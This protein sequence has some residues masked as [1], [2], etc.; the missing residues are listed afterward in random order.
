MLQ[1]EFTLPYRTA[2][3]E[4]IYCHFETSMQTLGS[5]A[6]QSTDNEHWTARLN[7]PD[8]TQYVR[9]SYSVQSA[10][11][12]M[13][14]REEGVRREINLKDLQ[15][16][17]CADRWFD[18]PLEHA[19][20][21]PSFV[22]A[23]MPASTAT[24]DANKQLHM[25]LYAP[26]PPAGYSW[27]IVGESEALGA[28][29]PK[30]AL[31]LKHL[32][33]CRWEVQLERE[34][35]IGAYK[36]ILRSN[37][38]P[39]QVI[40]EAGENRS[41]SVPPY[42]DKGHIFH[43]DIAPEMGSERWRT[44]GVVIPMFSLRSEGSQG[45]G[46]FGDLQTMID[47]AVEVGMHAVQLLPINDTTAT[48]TASDSY[49]YNAISVFALHP[50][51][52]DLRPWKE[53]AYY[54]HYEA[55]FQDLNQKAELDYEGVYRAKLACLREIFLEQGLRILATPA[56]KKFAKENADWL[57]AYALFCTLRKK[58]KT[59]N[60]RLWQELAT[61]DTY[62]VAHYL[63]EHPAE[64]AEMDFYCF[65]QFLLFEQMGRVHQYARTKGVLLKGD[66]PI[67]VNRNSA[68]AW[69][70]PQLFHFNGQAGAPPDVFAV[71]GQNWGFPTYNWE[72]MKRNGYA[73]W[74]RRLEVMAQ[75]FDAY[76]IDHVLGFF[77]I[78][79][80]PFEQTQGV[81]G[82]FRPAL[83]YTT[84]E[85]SNF[86]FASSVEDYAVP[87]ITPARLAEL[88]EQ[89][90]HDLRP[91]FFLRQG[92][93][94]LSSEVD[95]QR[96]IAERVEDADLQRLL[97]NV[98]AEVLFIA[99]PQKPSSYHPR[100]AGQQTYRFHSLSEEEQSAFTRLHD[101]FFYIR[102]NQFWAEE[103]LGK[104][105][106]ITAP[107]KGKAQEIGMLPCA[108]DLGMVPAS[109]KGVL[110][111]LHILSL[112]IQRMPKN[113]GVRF[114]NTAQNPYYSVATIAT[115]DMPPF[116]LWWA[117]QTE[118]RQAFWQEVLHRN[119]NAPIPEEATTD[120][121]AAVV[122][123]H[124][125]SPSM[126]CLLAWQDWLSISSEL[127]ASDPATEQINEPANPHHYWG[128]RMHLTLEALQAATDF[129]AHLRHFIA[130]SG[131]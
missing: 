11:G 112:E 117:R 125:T 109:V 47:W 39:L 126:L 127:R 59:A 75:A 77:R 48:G 71:A 86:G 4:S 121:C 79:E 9:Y 3:G 130:R 61:Y 119:V 113:Y 81:L 122:A 37:T 27:A 42:S 10:N 114:D 108:E 80:I 102:H 57:P 83:P 94:Y 124:L 116:R 52:L 5:V 30:D 70:C 128:Y 90:A 14:R 1:I 87:C 45:I 29:Q 101:H 7:L 20:T 69:T 74:Q 35:E 2:K 25:V 60:F 99:D 44:A 38:D 105:S 51:Y 49:P 6:L 93:Y 73:W 115:H 33:Q 85:I 36:Y 82:Y 12:M 56:Y 63:K 66:L 110:E 13:V 24:A 72:E 64:R 17:L 53:K 118:E 76:R 129:N 131:R 41:F 18:T 46:D 58:Y 55:V 111:Q 15:L 97:M 16:V 123:Q 26:L 65:V 106:A 78:W 34:K 96:K 22:S 107:T 98:C 88:N 62:A 8:G 84:E 89:T 19:F 54:E 23:V 32:R 50:L 91:Y 120:I 104:L 31:P 92:K 67:G 40:W 21:H 68:D 43:T 28:W 95:T 103:A 100:I